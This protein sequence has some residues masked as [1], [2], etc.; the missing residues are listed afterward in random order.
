MDHTLQVLANLAVVVFVISSMLSMGLSLTLQQ[1]LAPLRNGRL[2]ILA[3]V[4]NFIVVPALAYGIAQVVLPNQQSLG[5]GLILL[6]TAA[7]APFLPKLTQVAKGNLAF[8]VGLM[9]MLMVV[10]IIYL[11]LVLPFLLTGVKV[12]PL[13]IATSLVVL[14]LIPLAAGLFMNARYASAA[15]GLQPVMAQASNYSIIL[16]IVLMLVLNFNNVISVIGTGGIMALILFIVVTFVLGYF[17]GGIG[18]DRD[19][20]KVAGLGTAQ[21]NVSA[22]LVVGTSNFSNDPNVVVM[23]VVGALLMLIILMVIG[24][25]MGRRSQSKVTE[26]EAVEAF[27]S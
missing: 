16:V 4:L 9:V 22:A 3:L 21:R 23:L 20:K 14:M 5:T 18:S 25:E 19:I 12:N 24:G 10:T 11:P 17:V 7:G 1:I 26:P 2:V 15:A 8:A 13:Q 6:G 27:L